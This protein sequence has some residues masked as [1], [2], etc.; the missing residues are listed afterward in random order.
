MD[1]NGSLES[2]FEQVP[3]ACICMHNDKG[4]QMRKPKIALA[5]ALRCCTHHLGKNDCHVKIPVGTRLER[6]RK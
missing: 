1:R 2:L 3:I 6:P 5:Q 4:T